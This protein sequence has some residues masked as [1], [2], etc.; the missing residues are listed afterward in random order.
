MATSLKQAAS[1]TYTLPDWAR[2]S[3]Q[4]V[5]LWRS[6]YWGPQEQGSGQGSLGNGDGSGFYS[7]LDRFGGTQGSGENMEGA[8]RVD[9]A[10]ATDWLNSTGQQVFEAY[11]GNNEVARWMQD[12]QGNITAEPEIFSSNDNAFGLA[13]LAA[14]GL[15][16]GAAAGLWGGAGGAAGTAAG[17]AAGGAAAGTTAGGIGTLGTIAPGSAALAPLATTGLASTAPAITAAIPA[18][19]GAVGA[20]GAAGSAGGSTLGNALKTGV[21]GMNAGDWIQLG[22][23]VAS[24]AN[25]PKPP[26]TSGIND[27][28]RT[29]ANIGSRQQDL[30]EQVYADQKALQEKYFPLLEQQ[31]QLAIK[32]Q[33][34]SIE[35]GDAA[36]EDYNNVW[37]PAEKQL[38]ERSLNWASEPRMRAE[39]ERAGA[40]V[41]SQFDQARR[42]TARSLATAGASPEK[43]A[44]LEAAGRLEEAKAVGGAQG[45]ARRQVE[46]QGMSYL[47]NAARFGRSLPSQGIA[48]AGLAGQQGGQVTGGYGSLASATS[49]PAA[50]ANPLL[51]SAA[52]SS[53]TS[54]SLFGNRA[55]QDYRGSLDGYNSLMGAIQGAANYAGQRGWL[56]GP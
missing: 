22:G 25:K 31:M 50:A 28:A 2:A 34:K 8:R 43:I 52:S 37:R 47:D 44:A 38:A 19:G 1:K 48:A 42:E 32:E 35:R 17:G 45:T 51:S 40:D 9:V 33:G 41:S 24:V 18:V 6:P 55:Q 30:A 39:A 56:G 54:G 3:G 12:A 5:D 21:Q 20:A 53:A 15:L 49:A 4:A 13:S 36:W 10:G 27:A 14:G 26:D 46:S 29:T 7:P 16:G 11:G 23:L